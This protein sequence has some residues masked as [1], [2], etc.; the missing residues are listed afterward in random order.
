[1]RQ[2]ASLAAIV[3][4]AGCHAF[5][6]SAPAR[7]SVASD[8]GGVAATPAPGSEGVVSPVAAAP[9]DGGTSDGAVP[10]LCANQIDPGT[11]QPIVLHGVDAN[12]LFYVAPFTLSAV[13][14]VRKDGSASPRTLAPIRGAWTTGRDEYDVAVDDSFAYYI[15]G[16]AL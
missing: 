8:D 6:S 9:G 16:D 11:H 14:A 1:M 13:M 3:F 7:T 4:F 15:D 10:G 2:L 5:P 12:D